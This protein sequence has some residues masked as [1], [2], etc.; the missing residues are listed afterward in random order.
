MKVPPE[1]IT[2]PEEARAIGADVISAALPGL[3]NA[4][5]W[6]LASALLAN[7]APLIAAAERDR[8][9]QLADQRAGEIMQAGKGCG[10]DAEALWAFAGLLRDAP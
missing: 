5:A 8:I 6:N 2:V 4:D 3:S 9:R 7:A 1:T 10:A